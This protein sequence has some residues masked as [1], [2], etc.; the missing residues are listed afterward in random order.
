MNEAACVF[1]IIYNTIQS[2]DNRLSVATLCSMAGASRSGYYAWI[3]A[4]SVREIQEQQDRK[5]FDLILSAYKMHISF[6]SCSGT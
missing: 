5:D 2:S 1:E 4:A 3:K 6:E